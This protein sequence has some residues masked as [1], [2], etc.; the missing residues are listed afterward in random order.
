MIVE[1]SDNRFTSS[2]LEL[3]V[4]GDV[5][6]FIE[7]YYKLNDIV[8]IEAYLAG[9]SQF[10]YNQEEKIYKVEIPQLT[11]VKIYPIFLDI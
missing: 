6:D 4:W 10:I 3:T 1:L 9:S 7:K 11:V 5:V 2:I 8:L